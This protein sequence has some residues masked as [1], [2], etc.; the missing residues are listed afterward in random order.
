MPAK[1]AKI[2]TTGRQV[3]KLD[4]PMLAG[5]GNVTAGGMKR[6]RADVARVAAETE[7]FVN[8]LVLQMRTVSSSPADAIERP[9]GLNATL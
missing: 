6:D 4:G 2:L 3:P 7:L 9:S 5:R 8:L 1:G